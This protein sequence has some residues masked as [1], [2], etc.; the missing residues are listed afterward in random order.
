[1]NV[2]GLYIPSQLRIAAEEGGVFLLDEIDA[3]D[4]N[5]LLCLN[6]I[7]NGYIA[8]PD[9]VVL[10][11]KKFR[12]MSTSNP[13]NNHR[14]YNGRAKL[15]AATLDRFDIISV[16]KDDILEQSIV[17]YHTYSHMELIRK[18]LSEIN[19][20]TYISMRDSIRFQKRKELNLLG[21]FVDR[22]L[23]K[24]LI[25]LEKYQNEKTKIPE[26]KNIEECNA[27]KAVWKHINSS[28]EDT[29]IPPGKFDPDNT[30]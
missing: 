24:D 13:Q 29:P 28:A 6:T 8:F 30:F 17:D 10:L 14:D 27:L 18:C 22:L 19:S 1:M 4:P 15:D 3:S 11:N 12:L 25:A 26:F 16:E 2:N 20:G 5:V 21:S 7:E 9:K 23:S